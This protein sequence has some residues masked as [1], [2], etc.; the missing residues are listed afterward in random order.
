M[1]GKAIGGRTVRVNEVK[2]KSSRATF[3]RENHFGDGIR[4]R[5][6]DKI[7]EENELLKQ[8]LQL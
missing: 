5:D 1:D 4:D 6:R 2:S 7:Q 3:A 8:Y